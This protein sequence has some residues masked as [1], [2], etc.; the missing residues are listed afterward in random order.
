MIHPNL[1]I[2]PY[3]KMLKGM[4]NQIKKIS[5]MQLPMN[6]AVQEILLLEEKKESE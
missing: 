1:H 5:L 3:Y 4:H 6:H 2:I